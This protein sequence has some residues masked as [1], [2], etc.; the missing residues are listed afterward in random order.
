[1]R[2]D[3]SASLRMTGVGGEKFWCCSGW[4][5]GN[6]EREAGMRFFARVER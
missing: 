1:M 6:E 5:D 4:Q 2:R 3:P